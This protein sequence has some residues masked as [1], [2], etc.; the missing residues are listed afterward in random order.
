MHIYIVYSY[1]KIMYTLTFSSAFSSK[2][3]HKRL[4]Y[5]DVFMCK[6]AMCLQ[7]CIWIKY[8]IPCQDSTLLWKIWGCK[9]FGSLSL[10]PC[11][12]VVVHTRQF[13]LCWHF[14]QT[15]SWLNVSRLCVRNMTHIFT[16]ELLDDWWTCM[17]KGTL[18]MTYSQFFPVADN[19]AYLIQ[20][21]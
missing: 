12:I 18:S 2:M 3:Q 1:D 11:M 17:A 4:W 15:L 9:V 5:D 7:Q 20:L 10:F 14:G 16:D 8:L 13:A 6:K 19:F 21:A